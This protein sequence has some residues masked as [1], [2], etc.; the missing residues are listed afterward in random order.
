L[1]TYHGGNDQEK[2]GDEKAARAVF[3]DGGDSAQQCSS[4]VGSSFKQWIGTGGSGVAARRRRRGSAM[5]CAKFAW[6]RVLFIGVLD[7]THRG[8][9]V[10]QFLSLNQT[11]I[12]LHLEDNVKTV[13]LRFIT[14]RK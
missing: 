6:D 2:V 10:L 13:I 3:N 11:Q 1:P 12:Q 14:I 5:V 9:S 7:P 8:D 4:G